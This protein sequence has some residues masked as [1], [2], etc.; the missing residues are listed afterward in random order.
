[1]ADWLSL[2]QRRNCLEAWMEIVG[3][4]EELLFD[5]D[6]VSRALRSRYRIS[7]EVLWP[8]CWTPFGVLWIRWRTSS[9]SL[10]LSKHKTWS[11]PLTIISVNVTISAVSCGYG[12]IYWRNLHG[13]LDF[14]CNAHSNILQEHFNILQKHLSFCLCS[15]GMKEARIPWLPSLG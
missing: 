4:F 9:E 13:K 2:N 6:Y 3:L 8:W 12:Q 15:W 11:F 7:S 10:C 1:M 5:G 14:W